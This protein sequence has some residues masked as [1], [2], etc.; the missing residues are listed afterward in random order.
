MGNATF[1]YR[2]SSTLRKT[3]STLMKTICSILILL[4]TSF[5]ACKEENENYNWYRYTETGCMDKW[6]VYSNK[7]D[8]ELV[9]AVK[10]YLKNKSIEIDKIEVG[11]DSLLFNPCK[12]C[13]C[14]TGRYI[15]VSALTVYEDSLKIIGFY[16]LKNE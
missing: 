10:I 7:S 16:R 14:T 6:G 5:S 15:N 9:N 12:A 11:Y 1:C 8:A 4:I 3:N 2:Y 13:Y